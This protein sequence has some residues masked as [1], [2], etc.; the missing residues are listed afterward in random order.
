[1]ILMAQSVPSASSVPCLASLPTGWQLGGM[2]DPRGATARSRST[3]TWAGE[4]AV[5]VTLLPPDECATTGATEV[6]SDEVGM[7]RFERIDS[8]PPQLRSARTYVFE[9]GCV[10]YQ[11]AFDAERSA[12]LLFDADTALAMQPRDPLVEKV[13]DDERPPA[14]RRRRAAC[15]GGE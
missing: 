13:R 1:M 4:D 11:F 8:L 3:R 5:Q 15:P 12:S 7:R 10:T 2:Q 9:G 6:P 14:L